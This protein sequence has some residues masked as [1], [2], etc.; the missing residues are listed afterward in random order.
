MMT[1]LRLKQRNRASGNGSDS[2]PLRQRQTEKVM[3]MEIWKPVKGYEGYYS[4]SDRG[5]VRAEKRVITNRWGL[6]QVIPEHILKPFLHKGRLIVT[7][8]RCDYIN[9]HNVRHLVARAFIENPLGL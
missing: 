7:L 2:K 5:R 6:R 8:K 1:M 4:V 9:T 3:R